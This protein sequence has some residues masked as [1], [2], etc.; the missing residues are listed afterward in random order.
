MHATDHAGEALLVHDAHATL[1]EG[2]AWDPAGG[3]LVWIDILRSQV[4]RFRPSDSTDEVTPVARHIGAVAVRASGGLLL[5]LQDGFWLMDAA[6]AVRLLAPV[7]AEDPTTRMNDGAVDPSGAFYCGTM[8]YD[9]A[10]G[11]ASLYRVTP[12]GEVVTILTG[13]TISNGIDWSPDGRTCYYIDTPTRGV[14]AFDW[15]PSTGALR[16]RRRVVTIGD[17][18]GFPDGM[19]VD[20]EGFLW[21]ALWDGWGV[22]RYAPD[23]T[24]D[25]ALELPVAR[26]TACAFGGADLRDLYITTA[27]DRLTEPDLVAQPAAGGLF[28][29][30]SDVPG[31][32]PRLFRG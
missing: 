9:E 18:E 8:A 19:T 29:Y 17:G 2:P 26:V 16:N 3:T 30:R 14:D 6:G 1:G 12:D 13:S 20:A 15:D 5:A 7:E 25:R 22:R 23:G 11:R 32:P 24:L 31:Q 21:V 28:R 4:H 27:S 10:P